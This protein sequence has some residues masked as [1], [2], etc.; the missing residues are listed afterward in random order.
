[1]KQI[2]NLSHPLRML[3][4][5]LGIALLSMVLIGRTAYVVITQHETLVEH[6]ENRSV[7]TVTIPAHRGSITDRNGEPLAVS[8]PVLTVWA[9]PRAMLAY[10][11]DLAQQIA[12]AELVEKRQEAQARQQQFKQSLAQLAQLLDEPVAELEKKLADNS[13][14]GFVYLRR[15]V[16][17]ALGEQIKQLKLV[18]V[19]L[20][21]DYRRYYPAGEAAAH[22]VGITD[23]DDR[24]REGLELAFDHWLAG[25]PGKIKVLKNLRG[26]VVE[27][28][29]VMENAKVGQSLALSID[30]R[31]Q[32]LAHRELR[33]AVHEFKAKS[34]SLVIVDVKTGEVLAL[35]NYPT[36]NPNNRSTYNASAIRN[37]ALVDVFEPGSTVKPFTVAAALNSGRWNPSSTV[38]VGSGVMRIGKYT[39]RDV[40]RGGVLDLTNIL[41]KSSNVGVSKIALD[42]GAEPIYRLLSDVG[43][44]ADTGLG[45]PGESLGGF[46]V[47]RNWGQAE[48]A[49]MSYGYGFSATAVQLAQ[50]YA[51][52]GNNGQLHPLSLTRKEAHVPARQVLDAGISQTI[53]EM[54][55]SVVEEE[56]GGGVRAR[57]PGYHVAGKSGTSKKQAAGGGYT[58]DSYRSL[59]AGVGPVSEPRI[60]VSVVIDE[61]SEG[62]F[63]GGVVA[64]PVF[65]RVMA[66]SL[67]LLNVRPDN[68]AQHELAVPARKGVRS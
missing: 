51:V 32:Y 18:G 23:I 39:V 48:T 27:Q 58:E 31:L 5:L 65:S 66:G 67:R 37:R 41:K 2:K 61:P 10:Q 8:T 55:R 35:V 57:V 43:F 20:R 52:I 17:P 56:G 53:L 22:I 14:R 36:Y 25:V 11:T 16:A 7:R 4:L 6:G 34:G 44:G 12:S 50:A 60:A 21:E 47:Y 24:G 62:G 68:L 1:M 54:L 15:S 9:D 13:Q 46:P 30:L 45:F 42:I 40:S 59:F 63:Y 38:N 64:A 33:N 26:E 29:Q 28:L 19:H 49:A 3:T